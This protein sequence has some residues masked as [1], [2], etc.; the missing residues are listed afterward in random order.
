MLQLIPEKFLPS[1]LG[2]LRPPHDGRKENAGIQPVLGYANE[3][4]D[5][6]RKERPLG[7]SETGLQHLPGTRH[8]HPSERPHLGREDSRPYTK[9][10]S[11]WP[12][13]TIYNQGG[14]EATL[15]SKTI[16]PW[17]AKQ[18]DPAYFKV[19]KLFPF[20]FLRPRT[21]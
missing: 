17:N 16:H 19:I 11:R 4:G 21:V 6:V 18:C 9:G 7:G 1:W 3:E 2:T 12:G 8:R 13:E 10:S 5:H 15:A 20:T 14:L